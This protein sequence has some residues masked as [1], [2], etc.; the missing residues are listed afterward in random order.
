MLNLFIHWNVDP[1]IFHIGSLGVRWYSLGFLLAFLLGYIILD[2]KIFKRENVETKYLDSLLIYIFIAVLAGARL[3]HC[4]FYEPSYYLSGNHWIE[5]ILPFGRD[6]SGW[7]FTGYEGLASHGA[8][9]GILIALWLY[10]RNQHINPVWVLD[11]LVI[12]VALGGAFIR[13]GNLFNSEIYG[14]ETSLPW[15]IVFERNHETVPKHPTQLYESLSYFIIFIVSFVAYCRKNGKLRPGAMF[16]WW[17]I[18]LFGARFIIEFV[19][20]EQVAFEKGMTLD[21]GQWLSIPF[22][23]LGVLMCVMAYKNKFNDQIILKKE[24][25]IIK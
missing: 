5:I 13:L 6:A 21:M 20:E 25:K 2:K 23:L 3:G 7:H 16:G 10:Y 4:L 17:L 15:G 12:I 18:S 24:D 9:I 14:V 11:R 1:V 22:I 19:K 8:A